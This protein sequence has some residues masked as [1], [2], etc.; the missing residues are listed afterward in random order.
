[1]SIFSIL[2]GGDFSIKP[3]EC[4][5]NATC[6]WRHVGHFVPRTFPCV[7]AVFHE[8]WLEKKHLNRPCKGVGWME[9]VKLLMVGNKK[10]VVVNINSIVHIYIV[11]YIR[12]CVCVSF[13]FYLL[14]FQIIYCHDS[15]ALVCVLVSCA[16]SFW[17][18]L[19]VF[20][21]VLFSVSIQT[22]DLVI[23]DILIH[24]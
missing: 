7:L 9:P 10:T 13:L 4:Q 20:V 16:P 19:C 5:K 11:I 23:C 22:L 8:N 2:Q 14:F 6:N 15:R 3:R 17:S 12:I 1:M 18:N 21:L 24:L